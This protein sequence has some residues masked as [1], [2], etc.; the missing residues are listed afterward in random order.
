M[1]LGFVSSYPFKATDRDTGKNKE[2]KFEVTKVDFVGSEG[3][4]SES[5]FLY[6]DTPQEDV[7]G[8][9]S[10]HIR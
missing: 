2:T 10:A 6:T 8:R 4:S 3:N 1:F 9:F 5:L 7:S